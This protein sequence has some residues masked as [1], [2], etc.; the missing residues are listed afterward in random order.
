MTCCDKIT[1]CE[2]KKLIFFFLIL[3]KKSFDIISHD[4]HVHILHLYDTLTHFSR[5]EPKILWKHTMILTT[6][7]LQ[8]HINRKGKN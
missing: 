7:P 6:K 2:K 3:S 1:C 8:N 4:V 5:F